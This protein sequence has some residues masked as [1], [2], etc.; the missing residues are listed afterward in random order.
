MEQPPV[1]PDGL[2]IEENRAFQESFWRA[3]R[4]AWFFFGLALITATLGITGSGGFLARQVATFD[5]GSVEVP[6]F[7]RWEAS[8]TLNATLAGGGEE[9]SLTLSPEF[10]Q[11]FQVEDIDPPPISAEGSGDGLL[12]RFRSGSSQPLE[13][14]LHLR[15][16]APGIVSYRASIN[17]EPPQAVR[18]IVWP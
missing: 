11:T 3:E 2:Q 8:D 18:T 6:R 15:S 14:T 17:G 5:N 13:L 4:T 1:R 16:Q 10:F 7:S 12:Y 9:R